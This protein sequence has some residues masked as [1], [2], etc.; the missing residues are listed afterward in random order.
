MS[1]V[2][3]GR[4]GADEWRGTVGGGDPTGVGYLTSSHACTN[5]MLQIIRNYE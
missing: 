3:L 4:A 2:K 5:R 1:S